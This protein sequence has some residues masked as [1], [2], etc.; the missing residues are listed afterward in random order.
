M[1]ESMVRV[2]WQRT[3][4]NKTLL[5]KKDR[6]IM[7]DLHVHSNISDGSDKPIEIIRKAKEK[8]LKAVALTD[9]DNVAGLE[10]ASNEAKKLNVNFVKGIEFSV[11]YGTGR[12][13]HILGLGINPDQPIF[14]KIYNNY[15][16]IREKKLDNL[17]EQLKK[18]G[19]NPDVSEVYNFA[20]GGWLD[21]QAVAKWL[22]ANGYADTVSQAW[23]NIVD[24]IPYVEGELIKPEE[25]F[26]AIKQASGM[27]F[28]AHYHKWIGF[29]G[30]YKVETERRLKELKDMGLDGIERYYPSFT[31]K[32]EEEVEY[33]INRLNFIPSGGTDYH[34]KNRPDIELGNGDG[35]FCVPY[36]I[37]KNIKAFR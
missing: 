2:C 36:K 29:Q 4:K 22:A 20:T 13:I 12:L 17:F 28:L 26:Y 37:Y 10:E 34:G 23:V 9:H 32:N 25:A 35:D 18:Q 14:K 21:R 5:I 3:S 16:I 6:L 8:G 24:H 33:Y 27:S 7:I 11:S 1:I 31:R 15:R 19:I 30:Y